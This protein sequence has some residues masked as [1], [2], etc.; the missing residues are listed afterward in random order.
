MPLDESK[1]IEKGKGVTRQIAHRSAG[2]QI[3]EDD[4]SKPIKNGISLL[5]KDFRV[6][7]KAASLCSRQSSSEQPNRA[8][9]SLPS[10]YRIQ[11]C[12]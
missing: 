4:E 9:L 10:E 7:L 1:R 3:N 12:V 6:G 8:T 11:W 2:I 5:G